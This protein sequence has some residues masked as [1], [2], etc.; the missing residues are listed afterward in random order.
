MYRLVVMD[1]LLT[2]HNIRERLLGQR[3][4]YRDTV[5][6]LTDVSI[7]PPIRP[8]CHLHLRMACD[9]QDSTESLT[10]LRT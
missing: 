4:M 7:S 3:D 10:W 5:T 6:M 8:V 2:M 1:R 9:I